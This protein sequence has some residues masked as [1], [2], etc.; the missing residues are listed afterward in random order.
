MLTSFNNDLYVD[1]SLLLDVW[2]KR[3]GGPGLPV[4]CSFDVEFVLA[5]V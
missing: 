2:N 1:E 5:A 4:V 3:R